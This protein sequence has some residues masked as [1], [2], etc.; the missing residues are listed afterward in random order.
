MQ[1]DAVY[2][3]R[4]ETDKDAFLRQVLIHLAKQSKTPVDVVDAEFGAVRELRK[5]VIL[6]EAF[7]EG[8]CTASVGYDRQEP[9]TDY[10]TYKERVGDSYITRQR[11]VIKYRTVTDW[12]PFQTSYSGKAVCVAHNDPDEINLNTS[13]IA[14]A[15]ATAR[16]ES[17]E[18]VGEAQVHDYGYACVIRDCESEVEHRTA[19]PGDRSKDVRYNSR[20]E[21]LSLS[22]HILPYYEVDY[23]Y[24]GQRYTA[25]AYACGE[26]FI[27]TDAPQNEV[28]VNTVVEQETS[29]MK[30][31]QS[32]NWWVYSLALIGA[33][34][35]CFALDF[36][37]LWPL[38]ILLLLRAKKST[39]HYH[40]E[41]QA[42]S[43][44]L[45][46]NVAE[47]K[48][49]ALQS[50]LAR[51]GFAPFEGSSEEDG[52]IPQV[53]GAKPLNPITGRVTLCWVLTILLA[54]VSLF[55]TYSV[56]QGYVHSASRVSV[57]VVDMVSSYDPDAS[58]YIN[59][60]YYVELHYQ[61]ETDTLGVE[62]MDFKVHVEDDDGN[63]LGTVRSTLSYM[64]LEEDGETTITSMLKENQPE[65][66]EFFTKLY[67]ADFEDLSFTIEIGS[68][69]FEDGEYYNNED[70]DK[71]N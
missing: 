46:A 55:K 16:T 69:K 53:E 18:Q 3:M 11:A 34:V 60:C 40:K 56:Y 13:D 59:G 30:A 44:K 63:E 51:H 33:G 57:E 10:E 15:I 24:N 5:E 41:Y 67:N 32:R 9:Y 12:Q 17:M 71:F 48:K 23:T 43:D 8:S 21:V 29:H 28:D 38:V 66:N 65:K 70:Y 58:P 37:W 31:A 36:P 25:G 6:C 39:E 27:Q 54:I 14:R 64:E 26:I 20:H 35:V 49:A 47:S 42:L 45:S 68:I 2:T 61:I 52:D 50:A 62:Y 4:V 19:I 1:F 7:V 22:C